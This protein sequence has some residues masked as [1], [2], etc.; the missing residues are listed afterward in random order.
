VISRTTR[1]SATRRR[2]ALT[3]TAL[4]LT[5]AALVVAVVAVMAVAIAL[6]T[7]DPFVWRAGSWGDRPDDYRALVPAA[8]VAVVASALY[9]GLMTIATVR[10]RAQ[11]PG[12]RLVTRWV[13][14]MAGG[15]AAVAALLLGGRWATEHGHILR[16]ADC[17]DFRFSAAAWHSS[18][19]WREAQMAD[20]IARCDVFDGEP[21]TTVRRQLGPGLLTASASP[22]SSMLSYT[23]RARTADGR[24]LLLALPI[25]DDGRVSTSLLGSS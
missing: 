12:R 23:L 13:V 7:P 21:A 25:G 10:W 3:W 5:V 20:G 19:P 6:Q 15:T 11:W 4:L 2:Y 16:R 22:T 17:R 14:A 9:G 24:A 1:D 8:I 18:T